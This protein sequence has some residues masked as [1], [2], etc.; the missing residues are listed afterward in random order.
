MVRR[1]VALLLVAALA[2]A[3][4]RPPGVPPMPVESPTVGVDRASPPVSPAA[5][6]PSESP[7]ASPPSPELTG[8]GLA[9]A[10]EVDAMMAHLEAL[11]RVADEH[12][13][14]RTT[15]SRGF[16]ATVEH[17][18]ASLDPLLVAPPLIQQIRLP[19]GEVTLNVVADLPGVDGSEV[20][21]FGAHTDSVAEGPGINDDG[22]GVA[23]LLAIAEQLVGF[24]RPARTIRLGFWGAEELGQLGAHAYL[25]SLAP[26]ERERIAAYVNLEM[27][28]SP[29]YIRFVH[30][31]ADAAPGS[32][33]ITRMFAAHFE[34]AVLAWDP[35]D[36]SGKS[37]HAPFSAAGIPTGGLF[38]G[39]IEPKTD[40]Q[41]AR[42]GGTSGQP[43]DP[44]SHAACDTLANV[45]SRALDEMAD[46][47]AHALA[48]LAGGQ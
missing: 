47:V 39:G 32:E 43:A 33:A 10:V 9:A 14:T 28:G 2:A 34:S 21:V 35:I 6:E 16:E 5:G 17:V 8:V 11:Q 25:D 46:A 38:G 44:C 29:N 13:G 24:D 48:T 42:F 20:V 36:L 23:T 37:D 41:A 45:N 27:L 7:A 4:A 40:A 15:G 26:E 22:S 31:D 12:G 30:A 19:N 18:L 3:C 1:A